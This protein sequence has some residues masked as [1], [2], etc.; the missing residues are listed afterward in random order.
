M[1]GTATSRRWPRGRRRSPACTGP[2][3]LCRPGRRSHLG[4]HLPRSPADRVNVVGSNP[5][6]G[7]FG[8][9]AKRQAH[10]CA[11][12]LSRP[13][14]AVPCWLGAGSATATERHSARQRRQTRQAWTHSTRASGAALRRLVDR[15][16]RERL[17]CS[18]RARPPGGLP[19]LFPAAHPPGNWRPAAI[20]AAG[21]SASGGGEHASSEP[22]SLTCSL[23]S[24]DGR[25]TARRPVVAACAR[26]AKGR[27]VL[28]LGGEGSAHPL[29]RSFAVE[30]AR[31]STSTATT[32]LDE[33]LRRRQSLRGELSQASGP[34]SFDRQRDPW[35]SRYVKSCGPRVRRTWHF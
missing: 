25:T 21:G 5:A 8:S 7:I 1:V 9:P 15:A 10:G 19:E 27:R 23:T 2:R 28:V 26:T 22:T 11:A 18:A 3:A 6:G 33:L 17:G 24:R 12:A 35:K 30:L 4:Q 13:R 29:P 34:F 32:E 14:C 16:V 31:S 20:A